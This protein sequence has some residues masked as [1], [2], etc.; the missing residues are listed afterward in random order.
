MNKYLSKIVGAVASL[1]M[2]IGVG[3]GIAT[4]KETKPAFASGEVCALVTNVGSLASGDHI[5]IGNGTSGTVKFLSKTQNSNNR[6]A[7]SGS[8]VT[9]GALTLPSD[10]EVLTLGRSN[11]LWTL[12]ANGP[13]SGYLYAPSSS[14]NYLRTRADDDDDGNGRWSISI[15]AAGVASI[16][17]QGDK[18]RNQLKNNGSLFSCYESGQTSVSIYKVEGYSGESPTYKVTYHDTNKTGGNVPKDNTVYEAGGVVTVKGNEGSL[19]RTGFDWYGWSLYENGSGTAYGPAF[20]DSYTIGDSDV[21]FY[22]IWVAQPSIPSYDEELAYHLI[23]STVSIGSSYAARSATVDSQTTSKYSSATWQITV[24]NSTAQLGTNADSG[25]LSKATLGNGDYGAA[26]GLADALGIE[27]TTQ[28]YSAAICTTPMVNIHEVE[29][30]FTGINGGLPTSAWILSSTDGTTWEIE[31]RKVW[32]IVSGTKF[33]FVKNDDARQ[34][35]FVAFWNLP[36]SGGLKAFQLKLYGDFPLEQ[37][38]SGATEAYTDS[39][40]SLTSNAVSPTW[41]I[42]AGDTTAAGASVTSAGVV[43]VTGAGTVKVKA[44]KDGYEDA[45]YVI[46]FTVRPVVPTIA[47]DKNSTTGYTGLNEVISF[48]YLNL[49]DT[50]NVAVSNANVTASIQN[51]DGE[52][53]AEVNILFVSAGSSEVYLRN[54]STT[55]ATIEVSITASTVVIEGIP[56]SKKIQNGSTLDLG[57]S[58]EVTETG[59]CTDAVT[60]TSSVPSVATV[61]SSGVVTAVAPGSTVITVTP[62]SYPAGAVSCTVTVVNEKALPTTSI[63]VGDTVF[64]GCSFASKQYDGPSSTST[65]FGIGASFIGAPNIGG[66]ALEVVEGNQEN[67]FALKLLQGTYANKYITWLEGNSLNVSSTIDDNSSWNIT[68]D[69]SGNALIKNVNTS[70]RQIWW[71]NGSPRFACYTTQGTNKEVQLWKL[72]TPDTYLDS[73]TTTKTIHG[74]ENYTAEVLT[75]VDSVNIKFGA[76]I[77][78]E[79]WDA[80]KANWTISDYGVMLMK[81]ADLTAGGYSSIEDAY[82]KGASSSILK[83]LNKCAGGTPYS[84][85]YEDDD[86]IFTIRVN[87][88]DNNTY[89]NDVIYAAPYVVVSGQY[90]FLD[91]VHTSIHELATNYYNTGYE[92][93]SDAALSILKA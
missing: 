83:I 5:I 28:K 78:K 61:N 47:P 31:A 67:S 37:T 52:D 9:D 30:A 89:Y 74:H 14:N 54:G 63:A 35:A 64:L 76:T 40:V 19:V 33:A 34:Y 56:T 48:T 65:V 6:S 80:I 84:D 77:A 91:E 11:S 90:Y 39:T 57:S 85:P 46:T 86:C 73:A 32:N 59:S 24:G 71:N 58:I 3:F 36:N 15:T 8:T 50:L 29:V 93:L 45:Y 75:S 60:W 66:I 7:T 44:S 38:I 13:S 18:T 1:A 25:N 79:K 51:N 41:S 53:S 20:T 43:S 68:F 23:A 42:V 72:I 92:Y 17:A 81:S 82:N 62:T 21:D 2:V 27:T 55:L 10:A 69:G 4:N 12:S 16:T 49:N 26:E 70:T 87:F 22:P 88:P